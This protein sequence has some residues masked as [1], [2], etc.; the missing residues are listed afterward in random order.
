MALLVLTVGFGSSIVYNRRAAGRDR[1][2]E[3][4]RPGLTPPSSLEEVTEFR[5]K[6]N[7]CC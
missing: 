6:G 7:W 2:E 4:G 5:F 1:S 3:I